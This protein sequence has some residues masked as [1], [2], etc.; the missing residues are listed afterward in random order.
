MSFALPAAVATC[1]ARAEAPR[2]TRPSIRLGE[3]QPGLVEDAVRVARAHVQ[4][5]GQLTT[6]PTGVSRVMRTS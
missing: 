2:I 1:A 6:T 5:L 4:L 3:A